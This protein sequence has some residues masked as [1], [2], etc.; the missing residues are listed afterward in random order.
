MIRIRFF[1]PGKLNQRYFRAAQYAPAPQVCAQL[2]EELEGPP[3]S[4][5]RKPRTQP[6]CW[7]VKAWTCQSGPDSQLPISSRRNQSIQWWESGLTVG[8][9]THLLL[10]TRFFAT[11]VHLPPLSTDH[12][13]LRASQ[14]GPCAS[15]HFSSLPA[16]QETTFT[17]E[18]FRTLLSVCTC[19]SLWMFTDR[20]FEAAKDPGRGVHGPAP[21]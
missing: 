16:C 10:A 17:A 18:E 4:A 21:D 1:G 9:F 13:A 2:L 7:P 8:N 11:N 15:R 6:R 12:Q 20:S 19:P 5:C 14:R 3:S